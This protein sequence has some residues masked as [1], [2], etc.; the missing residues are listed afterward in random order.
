MNTDLPP[1]AD[2]MFSGAAPLDPET[3][4]QL[5]TKNK[6]LYSYAGPTF[7]AGLDTLIQLSSAFPVHVVRIEDG[8][9]R[10]VL[11]Q[12]MADELRPE[13]LLPNITAFACCLS[14]PTCPVCV[15]ATPVAA[16]PKR[17]ISLPNWTP[18]WERGKR[19]LETTSRG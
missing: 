4:V 5:S 7:Q 18:I 13:Q 17:V 2:A 10:R 6:R 1:A 16:R 19:P 15:V 12:L 9:P 3:Y 14:T 8:H 11:R